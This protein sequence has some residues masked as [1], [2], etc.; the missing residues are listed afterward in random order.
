MATIQPTIDRQTAGTDDAVIIVTWPGLATSGDVGVAVTLAAW[1]DKTFV[2][3]GTFTGSPAVVIEGS[4]DGT[5]WVSLSNRQGTAMSFTAGAMNT[6]QDRPV[7][8]RPRMAAG[9]GGAN[10]NVTVACHR[11]DLPGKGW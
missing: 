4:N 3:S 6:S 5:N 11:V 9:S 2:V 1:S 10:I 7:F 8:V